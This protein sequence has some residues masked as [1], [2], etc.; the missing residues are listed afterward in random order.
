MS[1][2]IAKAVIGGLKS[3]WETRSD[4]HKTVG[5]RLRL[6]RSGWGRPTCHC[7]EGQGRL[8]ACLGVAALI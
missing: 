3:S 5:V 1:S 6:E 7:E 8:H 2:R 4:G